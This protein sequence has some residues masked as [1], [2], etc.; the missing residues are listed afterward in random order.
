MDRG[1]LS[2]LAFAASGTVLCA[3]FSSSSSTEDRV[4]DASVRDGTRGASDAPATRDAT[5]E[6]GD[7]GSVDD[8]ELDT[9]L[10][11]RRFFDARREAMCEYQTRCAAEDLRRDICSPVALDHWEILEARAAIEGRV[12]YDSAAA[13]RCLDAIREATESCRSQLVGRLRGEPDMTGIT[14]ACGAV[15]VGTLS[16]GEECVPGSG[17]C[18][19]DL[20]CR[21]R[22]AF[23]WVCRPTPVYGVGVGGR[24]LT[25]VDCSAEDGLT[26][27]DGVCTPSAGLGEACDDDAGDRCQPDL[28][29]IDGICH[30]RLGEGELCD[31]PARCSGDL[32]CHAG[33]CIVGGGVGDDCED[34]P[35]DPDLYCL[36]AHDGVMC[37]NDEGRE[38]DICIAW[39]RSLGSSCMHGL[40]CDDI[41]WLGGSPDRLGAGLCRVGAPRWHSCGPASPCA[42]G[43]SCI[44]GTCRTA[45]AP[46]G[47]CDTDAVCPLDHRCERGRCRPL[48]G[49]GDACDEGTGCV[50]GRC[51]DGVC[52]LVARDRSCT[53]SPRGAQ[54]DE[55]NGTCGADGRCFEETPICTECGTCWPTVDRCVPTCSG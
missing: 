15:F 48:P 21:M 14:E 19:G 11:R 23:S 42:R 29:C 50:K 2:L 30:E 39:E 55:C 41:T 6:P 10:T 8:A 1:V 34:T 22:D 45:R 53:Q 28:D 17:D 13:R 33:R 51:V 12:I 18:A 25:E 16:E 46:G 3:C 27:R 47:E 9:R 38:G 44:D 20:H 31:G 54:Y 36:A 26:C 35:C 4:T 43:L 5:S 24:C 52:C 40:V 37:R 32:L 7:G 49:P